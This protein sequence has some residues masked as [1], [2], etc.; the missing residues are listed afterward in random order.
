MR[1]RA[2]SLGGTLDVQGMLGKGTTVELS[3]PLG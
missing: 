1:E 3:L 2:L